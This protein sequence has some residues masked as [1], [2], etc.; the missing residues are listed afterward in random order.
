MK[1]F[2]SMSIQGILKEKHL[3][4]KYQCIIHMYLVKKISCVNKVKVK[5][6]QRKYSN[7]NNH[8]T[9]LCM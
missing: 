3:I 1:Q 4:I 5:T 6:L 2:V 7:T 8:E 9:K